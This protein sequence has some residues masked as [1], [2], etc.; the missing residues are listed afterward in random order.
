MTVAFGSDHGGYTLKSALIKYFTDKG[1]GI[2]D[3]G[4]DTE[5]SCDYPVYAK[6]A[7]A[8]VLS[9]E[10]DRAILICKTGIGMTI[11]AN[12]IRGIRAADIS[13]EYSAKMCR[14]HNNCNVMCIGAFL[15]EE[16]KA[17][18]LADIFLA[19]DFEG[20]KHARRVDMLE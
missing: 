12:K 1:Y 3:V 17:K 4:T 13:D 8:K 9:G 7:C 5:Q 2:I 14:A 10:A 16:D 6:S 15:C 11:A 18:K 19:S 20:G